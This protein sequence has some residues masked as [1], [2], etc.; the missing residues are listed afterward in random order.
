MA[1]G[2]DAPSYS[3][4]K[5]WVAEFKHGRTSNEDEYRSGCP[6]GVEMPE[7]VDKVHEVVMKDR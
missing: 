2:D 1:L 6:V 3:M 4:V 5:N 7:M